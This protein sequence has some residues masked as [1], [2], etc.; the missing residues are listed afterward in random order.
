MSRRTRVWLK[1]NGEKLSVAECARRIGVTD[2]CLWGR[3]YRGVSPSEL[4][5]PGYGPRKPKPVVTPKQTVQLPKGCM[6]P[7]VAA[8]LGYLNTDEYLELSSQVGPRLRVVK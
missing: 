3:L 7:E 8:A 4:F 5:A 1:Y 6:S 2:M